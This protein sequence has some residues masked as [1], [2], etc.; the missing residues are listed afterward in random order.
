MKH[1]IFG[2]GIIL[3][4]ALT[5]ILLPGALWAQQNG[6]NADR[7][8]DHASHHWKKGQRHYRSY[9][10]D[11]REPS[12][13]DRGHKTGWRNCA[14]LS[15]GQARK[16]GCR[17]FRSDRGER[18]RQTSHRREEWRE[19]HRD[20]DRDARRDHDRDRDRHRRDHDHDH[21]RN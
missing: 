9:N 15:P 16:E 17:D 6:H 2:G 14:E 4:A 18:W 21:D 20:R 7:D 12:G 11:S 10:R 19:N 5:L 3:G 13:W 8:Q 1:R